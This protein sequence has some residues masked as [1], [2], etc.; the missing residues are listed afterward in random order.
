MGYPEVLEGGGTSLQAFKAMLDGAARLWSTWSS[1][2]VP[3]YSRGFGTRSPY[4]ELDHLKGPFKPKPFYDMIKYKRKK[5]FRSEHLNFTVFRATSWN[6][7]GLTSAY[8]LAGGGCLNGTQ[9]QYNEYLEMLTNL[10]VPYWM[11]RNQGLFP[12]VSRSLLGEKGAHRQKQSKGQS[13]LPAHSAWQREGWGRVG[14]QIWPRFSLYGCVWGFCPKM[15][16][17]KSHLILNTG[18]LFH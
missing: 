16:V 10:L 13:C 4:L 7:S 6:L 14:K 1:G 15:I 12:S 3:T 2:G 18:A 5:H 9:A 8:T 17:G 11:K